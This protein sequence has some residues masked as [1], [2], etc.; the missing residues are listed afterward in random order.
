MKYKVDFNMR[1]QPFGTNIVGTA[2]YDQHLWGEV[3][4]ARSLYGYA[5]A[6]VKAGG[7]PT[8]AGFIQV[9]PIAPLIFEVSK[10]KTYRFLE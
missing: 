4:K 2:Q 9:A 5:R 7:S 3:D 1:T 8:A 6:G 10:S